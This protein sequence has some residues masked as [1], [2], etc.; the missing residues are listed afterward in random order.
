[1]KIYWRSGVEVGHTL[2]CL[3]WEQTNKKCFHYLFAIAKGFKTLLVNVPPNHPLFLITLMT[4]LWMSLGVS[5]GLLL[6]TPA[7]IPLNSHLYKY[8]EVICIHPLVSMFLVV[9]NGI[10]WPPKLQGKTLTQFPTTKEG[11]NIFREC[12]EKL[13]LEF[14]ISHIVKVK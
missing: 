5:E 12:V 10:F 3:T 11:W 1:M 6:Y 8:K 2:G 9:C 7:G 14:Q 4:V 13:C